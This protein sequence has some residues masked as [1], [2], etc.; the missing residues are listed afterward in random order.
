M[1]LRFRGSRNTSEAEGWCYTFE[2]RSP[3]AVDIGPEAKGEE[4][5]FEISGKFRS[6]MLFAGPSALGLVFRMVINDIPTSPATHHSRPVS[7]NP[8]VS[9]KKYVSNIV[10]LGFGAKLEHI[11]A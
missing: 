11:L 2:L 4:I 10:K 1:S 3:W 5:C 7:R 6:Y 8:W 9:R